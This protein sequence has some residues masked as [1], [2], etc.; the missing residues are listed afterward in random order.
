[1]GAALDL[2]SGSGW[3]WQG[4]GWRRGTIPHGSA[5]ITSSTIAERGL[6]PVWGKSADYRR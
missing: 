5:W 2:E 6:R 3:V 4:D 1:M